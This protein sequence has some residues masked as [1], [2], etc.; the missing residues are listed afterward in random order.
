MAVDR[1]YSQA[2]FYDG[3]RAVRSTSRRSDGLVRQHLGRARN[4]L[5]QA[6]S[7]GGSTGGRQS[8]GGNA[9]LVMLRQRA[10]E[11]RD[12]QAI[13]AQAGR[14]VLGARASLREGRQL[15]L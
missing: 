6:Q 4:Q 5:R 8:A 1:R 7:Y 14:G 2:R 9:G 13:F 15:P 10:G 12:R 11:L 3:P